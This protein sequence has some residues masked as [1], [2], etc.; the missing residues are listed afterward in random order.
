MFKSKKFIFGL[1]GAVVLASIM[2]LGVT[3]FGL[4]RYVSAAV[5]PTPV[6]GTNTPNVMS[7]YWTVFLGSFAKNLGV[8]QGKFDSA[9]VSAIN[10]TID[11]AVKDGKMTQ[12]QGD[13]VKSRY[14]SGL[15]GMQNG[16]PGFGFGRG[17][18]KMG[19]RGEQLYTTADIA[20]ALGMSE[21]DFNTA[22]QSG[23]SIADIAKAQNKDLA[24]V[25]QTLLGDAKTK[26]N[27]QVTGKTLAQAQA[28]QLY[29]N[30]TNSIDIMLNS[31]GPHMGG[32]GPGGFGPGG[33]GMGGMRGNAYITNAEIAS[34]LGI[35][36]TDLTTAMQSG[37]SIA[38]IAK[39]KSKDL[40]TVKQA[41][42]KDAK[43][44]LDSAVTS[45]T[46]TQVQADNIYQKLTTSIDGMLNNTQPNK[47]GPGFFNHP[48]FPG[49]QN[50]NQNPGSGA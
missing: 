28:D 26:L 2:L 21:A 14:S 4:Y 25:K 24:T 44:K 16:F 12:A 6:P 43:T 8:D 45:K 15:S 42:L 32:F 34:A 31:A 38:D 46:L 41:L 18:G 20:G 40:A 5:T 1:I 39:T 19:M 36:E 50:Q 35:S 27:S 37:K 17:F 7:Q 47:G 33:R 13:T 22:L 29:Q 11:Q 23:K 10:T 9:F 30:L 49:N 3:G 48:G